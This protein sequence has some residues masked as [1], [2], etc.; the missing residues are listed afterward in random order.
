M[1][2]AR[3]S[4][5]NA[6]MRLQ[7][8]RRPAAAILLYHRVEAPLADPWNM[9]VSPA[10]FAEHM[11]VLRAWGRTETLSAATDRLT[12]TRAKGCVVAVTFDDGYGDNLVNALPVLERESIPATLYAVS[13]A[14][15]DPLAFWWDSLIKALLETSQLPEHLKI[16]LGETSASWRL[17]ADAV[18][19][20]DA[21]TRTA[22]WDAD[23]EEP[24]DGRQ[25][26]LL[27]V[28]S[29][30]AGL[31]RAQ[32]REAVAQLADWAGIGTVSGKG[33]L[34]SPLTADEL[35]RLAASPLIDVGGHTESHCDLS[36]TPDSGA[37]EEIV[38]D[39][40]TL[41][42]ITGQ[43]VDHFGHPYGR[44]GPNTRAHLASAGYA[45]ATSSVFGVA[46]PGD[47]CLWLPRI[48][49]PDIGGDEFERLIGSV[50][51]LPRKGRHW[52]EPPSKASS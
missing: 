26:L 3:R 23:N 44:R 8:L 24:Q 46:T 36:R 30:L 31:P 25:R 28:W 17:G 19:D 18:Y 43:P 33:D 42:E 52:P 7:N 49:V 21:L 38:R 32:R 1:Q 5:R 10:Y 16:D 4:A 51:G 14:L 22:S 2:R 45:T 48:Q 11:A 20:T 9:A 34:G 35:S 40:N 41:R 13:G 47:D 50:T 15:G 37:L 29:F 27:E 12:R 39:R 6:L